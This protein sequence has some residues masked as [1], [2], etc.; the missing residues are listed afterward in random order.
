MISSAI[1]SLNTAESKN[2]PMLLNGSRP[3][4]IIVIIKNKFLVYINTFNGLSH[5]Q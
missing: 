2:N 4:I 1:N 5:N 3:T